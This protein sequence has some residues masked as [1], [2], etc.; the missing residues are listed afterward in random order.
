[1]ARKI[2]LFLVLSLVMVGL[3]AVTATAKNR[4]ADERLERLE[5]YKF[6]YKPA[7]ADFRDVATPGSRVSSPAGLDVNLGSSPGIQLGFSYYDAQQNSSLG[8]LTDWRATPQIHF[9]WMFGP[10]TDVGGSRTV[11]YNVY[12]GVNG[13]FP[14]GAGVGCAIADPGTQRAGFINL[15]VR[16]PDPGTP[17]EQASA[18]YG[19]HV[20]LTAV[21][22][23]FNT[24]V[25]WDQA[26]SSFGFCDWSQSLRVP[27]AMDDTLTVESGAD[28]IWP[29]LEYQILG[30]DTVTYAC[31]YG[32]ADNAASRQYR[33]LPHDRPPRRCLVDADDH[34]QH[35]LPAPG[36][37]GFASK[38]Q[39]G[40]GVHPADR[41][42]LDRSRIERA[43]RVLPRVDQSRS[44]LG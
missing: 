15:D 17:D 44:D 26:T 21:A 1:M 28:V 27:D 8:R 4:V 35:V 6:L 11:A 43:R 34:R 38:R 31:S 36:Y 16:P 25:Y 33:R 29:K 2:S 20:S 5:H 23:N 18:V 10:T 37:H 22:P 40:R 30:T 41:R 9:G 32:S 39:S 7:K 24:Q 42:D 12:D 13:N 19:A 3:L 14:L